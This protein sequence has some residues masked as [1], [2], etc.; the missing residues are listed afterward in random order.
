MEILTNLAQGFIGLFQ[1]GG[2]NFVGMVT[3]IVPTL[4]MLLVA[5]NA[6]I[7]FVGEKR[8]EKLARAS[9]KNPI[10]RYLILPVIGTFFFCNPMTLS[11]GKF[12]PER[13]KPSYY[14]A[15]SFSCHTMNGLFPHVDPSE[16]FVFL[17]IAAGITKLGLPTTDL[18][19][20]YFLVGVITNFFRGWIT[21]FT[22]S[23]VERQQKVKLKDTLSF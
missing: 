15:A 23:I 20:R 5:M 8:I 14:A 12:L 16:L 1:E 11:L 4:I 13:Y 21:D 19:L 7:R 18:A 3:G 10:T 17:G 22:T 2:K 9:A 6:I